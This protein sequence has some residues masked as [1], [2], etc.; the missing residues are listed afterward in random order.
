MTLP[1]DAAA[2]KALPLYSGFI[3]YFPDAMIAVAEL[4]RVGNDQHS[5][6]KPLHWDRSKS[7]DE[8][9]ALTR[10]LVEAGKFD[11][12]GVRHSTKLAWRAMANLQKELERSYK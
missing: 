4:S 5:P 11:I 9:D 6:G 3:K 12:D 2:R 1:L 8:L 7:G 10:H